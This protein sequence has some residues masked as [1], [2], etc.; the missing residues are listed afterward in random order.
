MSAADVMIPGQGPKKPRKPR[1]PKVTWD[2]ANLNQVQE[3]NKRQPPT[4]LLLNNNPPPKKRG[5]KPKIKVIEEINESNNPPKKRKIKVIDVINE[6][7]APVL[8][9]FSK[10]QA[11][12]YLENSTPNNKKRKVVGLLPQATVEEILKKP[13]KRVKKEP[14]ATITEDND[15]EEKQVGFS[16]K[17]PTPEPGRPLPDALTPV[18][19]DIPS[20]LST[21]NN[22]VA[23]SSSVV[24]LMIPITDRQN[25]QELVKLEDVHNQALKDTIDMT[26]KEI[27][28]RGRLNPLNLI[29]TA[30][31]P[32]M[33]DEEN[34]KKKKEMEEYSVQFWQVMSN[35]QKTGKPIT[36]NIITEDKE[37]K[38]LAMKEVT[39][40]HCNNGFIVE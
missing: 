31:K 38:Q 36:L 22:V 7:T 37:E 8:K 29:P 18:V 15:K 9:K 11:A 26:A 28:S 25:G 34:D 2:P 17:F 35:L 20:R 24:D 5:P 4:S 32:P 13:N 40:P 12:E 23:S 30:N 19:K 1:T 16:L 14:L 3:F 10:K 6:Q 21:N 39:C 27:R 33:N